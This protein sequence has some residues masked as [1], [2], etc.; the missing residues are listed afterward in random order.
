[1]K[2]LIMVVAVILIIFAVVDLIFELRRI[3]SEYK[4][5]KSKRDIEYA[6]FK[7]RIRKTK[8]Y[9]RLRKNIFKRWK[10]AVMYW[11]RNN[12]RMPYLRAKKMQRRVD[13]LGCKYNALCYIIA[14]RIRRG[15]NG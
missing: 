5:F 12:R 9:M 6:A 11:V 14:E 1:M 4:E 15:H 7:K 13:F 10:V 8:F 3:N 2:I